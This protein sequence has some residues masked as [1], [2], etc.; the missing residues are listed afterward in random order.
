[1]H[2]WDTDEYRQLMREEYERI[3]AKHPDLVTTGFSCF[4]GWFPI[5][6]R[7][8]DTVDAALAEAPYAEFDLWQVK[9]KF[10]GLRIYYVVPL[11][12]PV[13]DLDTKVFREIEARRKIDEA[14]EQ[15]GK[16]AARTCDVCSNEGG[17]R[18][19][20]GWFATRCEEHADDGEPYRRKGDDE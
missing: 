12:K 17:L 4:M 11:P 15:A 14:Y 5:I 3:R 7:F 19:R 13:V 18:S 8:F 2:D 9:E 16:E 10:G 1:M 6:E 20:N